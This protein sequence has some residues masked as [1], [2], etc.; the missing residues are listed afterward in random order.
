MNGYGTDPLNPDTDNDFWLD[1]AEVAAGYDPTN[2]ASRPPF[3][4]TINGG[5]DV[6]TNALVQLSFPGLMADYVIISESITM[7]DSVTNWFAS[8]L[9]YALAN[10]NDGLQTLY[11]QLLKLPATLSPVFGRTFALDT[12]PPT[13]TITSPSN[14]VTVNGDFVNDRDTDGVWRSGLHN[15]VAGKET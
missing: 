14:G 12:H 10:T 13:V 3:S 15:L 6:V 11:V 7:A 1:S 5:T 8:P 9:T 2:S 4:F